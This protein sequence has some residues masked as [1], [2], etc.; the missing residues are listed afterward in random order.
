[1]KRIAR[2][3][4]TKRIGY[5]THESARQRLNDLARAKRRAHLT[6]PAE[7]TISQWADRYRV[8]ARESSADYGKWSTDR[9]PYLREIMDA[10]C[11]PNIDEVTIVAPSQSGKSEILLNAMG[12]YMHIDPS[13][14]LLV[15]YSLDEAE[16]FS[17]SRIAPML[18]ETAVL[19]ALVKDPRARDSG[20]TLLTKEFPGGQL[21]I[22]GA[23]SPAGM[24]SK[25]KKIVFLDERDRHPRSA[26]TE[27][28]VKLIAKARTTTYEDHG[29]KLIEVSSPGD[30]P[31][32]DGTEGSLIW[33]SYLEGT[34]EVIEFACPDCKFFQ[35]LEHD[36]LKWESNADGIVLTASVHYECAACG[37]KI[38]K[39]HG[40]RQRWRATA[41]PRVPRKRSFR[42]HGLAAA[43]T[44]WGAY[45]QEFK[46][47]GK[48][49]EKL[50]T[51]WNTKRGE[52][53]KD[54][55]ME[56]QK[57]RLKARSVPYTSENWHAP[58]EVALLTAGVDKQPDRW[59]VT[60]RGWGVGEQSW[61]IEH[62]VLRCDTSQPAALSV[63]HQYRT[64]RTW[65]HE[66]GAVMKIRAMCIDAGDD[67]ANV[68]K[69]AN[70]WLHQHV[71]PIKGHN[72]YEASIVPRKPSRVKHGRLWVIGVNA[73]TEKIY[74]RLT[75]PSPGPGYLHF[76]HFASAAPPLASLSGDYIDQLLNARR[77]TNPKTK[78][79]SWESLGR[80]EALDCEKY[81]YA[82]LM[83]G[84]VDILN[85][86][87]EVE[88]V[89]EEG[90]QRTAGKVADAPAP[91]SAAPK[92]KPGSFTGRPGG[93]WMGGLR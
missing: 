51:F 66:S 56:D 47:A 43:F 62:A 76:N 81:A 18:R 25:P 93:S 59:E 29:R 41:R 88:R 5:Q 26:G 33:P 22:V 35:T 13:P 12:Y 9:A 8:L 28:D 63:L 80:D 17:K 78:R 27:G 1:M 75:M 67:G 31:S 85:L 77:V 11:D 57:A 68:I 71:Y 36:R 52:C 39:R 82:A 84:P 48:D 55:G 58:R 38:R 87:R 14:M 21:D 10:I 24:A 46:N 16:K 23:N 50:K 70:T 72:M 44:S 3:H 42:I 2:K 4:R 32:E 53:W 89:M 73:I 49:P 69:Y 92:P 61:L 20:N 91:K 90:K 64:E 65:L 40:L 19:R 86:A 37:H 30:E 34:Q 74:R 6:A 45:A 54:Q 83:L 15:Q 79:R 60:V 7:M